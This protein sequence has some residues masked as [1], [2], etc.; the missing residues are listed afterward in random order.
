MQRIQSN[1]W[2]SLPFKGHLVWQ[3]VILCLKCLWKLRGGWLVTCSTQFLQRALLRFLTLF[4][5]NTARV[6][7]TD[8]QNFLFMVQATSASYFVVKFSEDQC[9]SAIPSTMI[10]EP[11]AGALATDDSC[12]VHW[13]NDC[14]Y[15]T[16][17]LKIADDYATAKRYERYYLEE[18]SPAPPPRKATLHYLH[19]SKGRANN[20]KKW[21]E[22]GTIFHP[23]YQSLRRRMISSSWRLVSNHPWRLALQPTTNLQQLV[24]VNGQPMKSLLSNL[25][26][27]QLIPVNSQRTLSLLSSVLRNNH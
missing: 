27:G 25:S 11:A 9:I 18:Q 6:T 3:L 21:R 26:R 14:Q 13:T 4:F 16:K 5:I 20:H 23:H 17:V 24:L 19:L 22:K 12:V 8:R 1:V 2:R 7:M 15:E 10:I